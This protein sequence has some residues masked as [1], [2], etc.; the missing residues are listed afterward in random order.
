MASLETPPTHHCGADNCYSLRCPAGT[1]HKGEE[2]GASMVKFS[3]QFEGQLVPEWKEA[4]VDYWQLKKDVK[5]LQ[6]AAGESIVMPS[7]VSSPWLRQT[8]PTAHWM[9]RLPF[10]H[11][12]GHHKGPAAIQA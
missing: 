7:A 11:P 1:E 4:F 5:K 8:P 9:M 2:A 10:L 12:H 3:K 6:T